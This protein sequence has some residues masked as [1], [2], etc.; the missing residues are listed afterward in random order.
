MTPGIKDYAWLAKDSY[1]NRPE[2]VGDPKRRIDLNGHE[3]KV[4]DYQAS[5]SGFHATAYQ[6]VDAPHGIVIAYRGTDPDHLLTTIQDTSVDAIMV[7]GKVNSQVRDA[8]RF[9]ERVLDKARQLGI[10]T[11]SI[12]VTGHSLGGTLAEVAAWKY[13]L[14]GQ[15]FNAFGA[16]D[17]GLGIPEGSNLVINHVLD[18]DPVSAGGHH[19]GTV[20]HYATT[21][22]IDSLRA[23]GYLDGQRGVASVLHAMRFADHSIGNFAPDPGQGPSVLNAAN[24]ARAREHAPAITAFRDDVHNARAKLHVAMQ[25]GMPLVGLHTL[26]RGVEGL[27]TAGL[28]TSEALEK[29]REV[30]ERETLRS[31]HAMEQTAHHVAQQATQAYEATRTTVLEGIHA[32]EQLAHDAH[33]AVRHAVVQGIHVA[34]QVARKAYDATRDSI[35]QGGHATGEAVSQ[36]IDAAERAVH[37]AA[38]RASDAFGTLRYPGQ[39]F[40][41]RPTVPATL[42]LD[43][44][45]HQGHALFLQARYG[46]HQLDAERGRTPDQRSNNLAAALAVQAR[47]KNLSHIDQVALS[48][49]GTRAFAVQHGVVNQHAQVPT[50][51]AVQTSIAQSSAAWQQVMQQRQQEQPA[52]APPMPQ[53]APSPGMSR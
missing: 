8:E 38:V 32:G 50:A 13:S 5:P 53:P 11:Q 14:H 15:T 51:E 35:V 20:H 7:G 30:L 26:A 42:S 19:F 23:A 12:T 18:A 47:H 24:E 9:T 2:Y 45:A 1:Q 16:A 41:D 48:T 37:V 44:P 21:A 43:Q 40:D 46:V 4:F 28:A 33:D 31:A 3:Y 39:W 6:Q 52:M 36:G 27:T 22:D 10:S 25:P 34:E 49:D 17:L 29:T